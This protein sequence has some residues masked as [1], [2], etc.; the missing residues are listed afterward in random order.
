MREQL[1]QLEEVREV[2]GENRYRQCLF[3]ILIKHFINVMD[4]LTGKAAKI[5]IRNLHFRINLSM[6]ANGIDKEISYS[7][8][9]NEFVG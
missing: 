9:Y 1:K 3:K 4:G 2:I 5:T 8:V 6:K 7:T